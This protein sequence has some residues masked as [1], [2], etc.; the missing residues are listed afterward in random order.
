MT[1]AVRERFPNLPIVWGGWHPSLFGRECLQ[2]EAAIDV[3][4]QGQGEESFGE[5]LERFPNLEG[6][7][8]CAYRCQGEVKLN[9]ARPLLNINDFPAHNYELIAVER[10]FHSKKWRQLDYISS[11]GCRFRCSFCADPF[12]YERK[13]VGLSP[14]RIGEEIEYLWKKYHFQDLNFQDETFFTQSAR[15]TAISEEFLR[16]GIKITWAGTLRADQGARLSDAVFRKC[17]AS[18]LRRVMIGVESGSPSMLKWMAKDITL[19]QVFETAEKCL[20]H[21]IGAI[22]PFIVGFPNEPGESVHET[23]QVAR[24]LRAMSPEFQIAIF[25]YLP[26]PGSP[27]AKQVEEA[28]Y[29]LPKTLEEWAS[30]DYVRSYGPWVTEKKRQRVESFKFYQRFAWSH[31]SALRWPVRKLAQWRCERLIAC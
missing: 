9:P 11:Q 25:F 30:F 4:V 6:T 18:G 1:R 20:R 3:T 29:P 21:K 31:P 8:G 26:Y 14:K 17:A 28:G 2:E 7:E 12:V 13:W 16:R 22:F 19:E 23:L 15:L 24:R 5:L 10:Y 27:I